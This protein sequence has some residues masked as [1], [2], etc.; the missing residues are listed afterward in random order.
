MGK[1]GKKARPPRARVLHQEALG[2]Q[3]ASGV[4]RLS[5]GSFLVVDDEHG[6]FRRPLGGSAEALKAGEAL[7]DLEGVCVSTDG[8]TAWLLS[9][10]DGAV[11]RHA[12]SD[13]R[14]GEGKRVGELPRWSKHKNQGWEGIAYAAPG[15]LDDEA[16][17]VAVHQKSPR[18]VGLF[19]A[20]SLAQRAMLSLPRAVKK[21]L[22]DLNDVTIH[23]TTARLVVVS[24][25]KG[26][27]VEL[28]VN[29]EQ[30]EAGRRFRVDHHDD[31]VPEGITYDAEGR[32]WLV[33]D[34]E[35]WLRELALE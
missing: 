30:L 21:V 12:V 6:V 15:L 20:A 18:A 2:V 24:G 35:G 32:L 16:T 14:L 5:D 28:V 9:E 26:V 27:L 4:A 7:A 29:G 17:L 33:T 1:K 8:A 22:G 13:G 10:R 19:D 11:W 31:D 23:P 34:G 3:E 25:K